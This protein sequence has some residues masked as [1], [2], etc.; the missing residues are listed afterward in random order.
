VDIPNDV[1]A[2][3]T[4]VLI[5]PVASSFHVYQ[6]FFSYGSGCY[7][8][9]GDD[10]TNHVVVIVGWDDDACGGEGAWQC[11]NSWGQQ[12]GDLGGYFWIKYGTCRIGTRAARP[13]YEPGDAIAYAAASVDDSAGNGDGFADPGES[14]L[15]SLALRGEVLADDHDGVTASLST[16]SGSV[17]VTQAESGFGTVGAEETVWS[18][19]PFGVTVDEFAEVGEVAE[20]V[21][22]ITADGGAFS[23]VDTFDLVLGST[24]VLLVDDDE[25]GSTD[26]Y[27]TAA[28]DRRGLRYRRWDTIFEG[29][30][31]RVE[32][33]RFE[34]V[35]WD[36]GLLGDLS[37][38]ERASLSAFLDGGGALLVSGQD[39]GFWLDYTG[40][41][42][43]TAFLNDYL[44]ADYVDDD[45]GL[46]ALE[47]APGDPIG[48]GLYFSLNGSGSAGNQYWPDLIAP[49]SGAVSVFEYGEYGWGQCG[50]LRWDAGHRLA[51]FAFGIEG[52]TGAPRQATVLGRA[53]DWLVGGEWPDTENPTVYAGELGATMHLEAGDTHPVVWDASDNVG[54][55]SVDLLASWDGGMSYPAVIA[56]GE[57]D[58]GVFYWT[59]P[60]TTCAGLRFRVIARDSAGLASFDDSDDDYAVHGGT[61]GAPDGIAPAGLDLAVPNP[62]APGATIS[63]TVPEAALTA[64]S[65]HDVTG[66][67]VR[68]LV[69]GVLPAG[70]H[71]AAWDGSDDSGAPC[72]SGV[73]FCRVDAAGFEATRKLVLLK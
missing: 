37:E 21:L 33:D 53:L 46:R 72:A 24:P 34:A 38:E 2:I 20:C 69:S 4:Q 43:D 26:S 19:Q 9:A 52:I 29:P 16:T 61:A 5:G 42:E 36:C 44:H 54:V 68:R 1:D 13:L 62:L 32:M 59:V 73:Y 3:K 6:D 66:R 14:V 67:L 18:L 48:D 30:P 71:S 45:P 70:A 65:I 58:D 23:C 64:V 7:E 39:V 27:F 40:D 56:T 28:L 11:K 15:L 17:T 50:A 57:Q 60:D 10:P 31:P 35:V 8:H 63:F 47:G 49:R 55:S 51:Y 41:P 12:W 22:S 25:G